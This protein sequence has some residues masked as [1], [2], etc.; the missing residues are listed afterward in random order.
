MKM[1]LHE[2]MQTQGLSEQA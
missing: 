1:M 2:V